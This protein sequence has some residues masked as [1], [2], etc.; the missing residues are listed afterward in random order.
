MYK[1]LSIKDVINLEPKFLSS[2]IEN[3]ILNYLK[4]KYEGFISKETGII[5]KILK[6]VKR[7]EG[8]VLPLTAKIQYEVIFEALS[9]VPETNEIV[10]GKIIDAN[11]NF[12]VARFDCFD[13]L[14]HISQIMDD[15]ITFNEKA[16]M[17][18][19]KNTKR[20]LKVG[21]EIIAKIISISYEGQSL[22]IGLTMRQPGL[23]NIQWIEEEKRKAKAKSQEKEKR[24]TK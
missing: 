14:I 5:L 17:F 15:Y 20:N 11:K 7:S 24:K 18:S 12:A 10:F 19:G 4:E 8:T 1:I 6:I 23:G 3:S 13:G 2:N 16:K 21:D 22:K 9:Y